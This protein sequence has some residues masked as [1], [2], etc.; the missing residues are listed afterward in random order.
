MKI[1]KTIKYKVINNPSEDK[2][3]FRLLI[4]YNITTLKLYI[5][6]SKLFQ[7]I[8]ILRLIHMQYINIVT[9]HTD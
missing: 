1:M 5:N 9:L 7:K 4:N 8:Y 6:V 3:I 2:H